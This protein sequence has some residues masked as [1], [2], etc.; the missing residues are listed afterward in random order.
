MPYA[1]ELAALMAA[2]AFSI[3][4][5]SFTLA[6]RSYTPI[7]L[8]RASL[9]LSMVFLLPLHWAL[10]GQALPLG[11]EPERWLYLG[12]SGVIGFWLGSVA[13]VNAFMRIGPRLT[14]LITATSPILSTIMAWV[15]LDQTLERDSLFGILLTI[16]GI[17]Y[18]VSGRRGSTGTL[19]NG[20]SYRAGVIFALGGALGQATSFIFS[21]LGLAAPDAA[22]NLFAFDGL[23]LVSLTSFHPLTASLMRLIVAMIAIWLAAVLRGRVISSLQAMRVR[24]TDARFLLVGAVTGP[25]IGASLVMISLQLIPVGVSSTLANLTPLFLI[26]LSALVFKEQITLRA[27][28]GTIIAIVG[29]ALLFL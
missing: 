9:P 7:H 1:G 17:I 6:G 8:M 10:T 23:A 15:L 18:V 3:T 12:V 13:I 16:G 11:L 2:V 4:S 26:P 24:P 14:L 25:V 22:V 28:V 20:G 29:V 21:T 5:T 19:P 27:G